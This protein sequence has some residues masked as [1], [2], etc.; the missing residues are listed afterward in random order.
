[1][2]GGATRHALRRFWPTRSAWWLVLGAGA[3]TLAYIVWI[4]VGGADKTHGYAISQ[5]LFLPVG[6]AAVALSIQ[7]AWSHRSQKRNRAAWALVAASL[8]AFWLGEV[9]WVIAETSAEGASSPSW[10]DLFYLIYYPLLL[11]ALMLLSARSGSRAE[12]FRTAL[13]AA[14][15]F[16][17]GAVLV[18][19]FVLRPSLE[20][21]GSTLE[22]VVTVAYPTGDLLLILGIASLAV[23]RHRFRSKPALIALLCAVVFGFAADLGYGYTSLLDAY[24]GTGVFEIVYLVSWFL[25]ALAAAFEYQAEQ[26]ISEPVAAES[27]TETSASGPHVLPFLAIGVALAV[28]LWALRHTFSTAEAGAAVAAV[29]VTVL[30]MV[31]QM[32]A[33]SHTSRLREQRSLLASEERFQHLLRRTQFSVDHVAE[34]MMWTDSEGQIVDV[35]TAASEMLDYS[36][37]ELLRMTI[38]QI[39]PEFEEDPVRWRQHWDTTKKQG[40]RIIE[41]DHRTKSGRM[42]PV[43]VSINYLEYSGEEFTVAF[44]HDISERRRAEETLRE[45][46]A[47]LRQAQKMDAIGQLAGGIAHDFNNLLTTIVGYCELIL[48]SGEGVSEP[49]RADVEEIKAAAE[50]ATALTRRILLFSRQ[51]PLQSK[52]V[53]LNEVVADVERLLSRTL[54]EHVELV[55]ILDPDAG[56]VEV[57]VSQFEQAITNLAVNARDAMPQGGRLTIETGHIDLDDEFCALRPGMRPGIHAVLVVSD[58]GEGMDEDT[59]VRA[60][61][62]FF[63][64]KEAGKGTGLGLTT[65]YGTAKQSGGG[66]FIYSEKGYGSAVKIYLPRVAEARGALGAGPDPLPA[67]ATRAAEAPQHS[68]TVLVVEDED[69]IRHLVKR[70]L[71]TRGYQ[72]LQAATA[73]EAVPILED[74][75]QEIDM[76]LTDVILPGSMQGGELAKRAVALRPNLP[77]LYMSGY[78]HDTVLQA[79]RLQDGMHYLEKPFT[80]QALSRRVREVLDQGL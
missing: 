24:N 15:I 75:A 26:R 54:G 68:E 19:Y 36:N 6:A 12:R 46:A 48:G 79:G 14:T 63:T 17:G 34:A 13:D 18:W 10:A 78:T 38:F 7:A 43:E 49:V 53:E 11:A 58:T 80:P 56:R 77:I 39:V 55:T 66:V 4:A 23:G 64:T 69:G 61:E 33:M 9:L 52:V 67:A 21:L 35:N 44:A 22:G 5:A 71:A 73:D 16:L 57:D 51:Q 72:V 50:R 29:L 27:P 45:T 41:T 76:L 47:Q 28:L 60:F 65:V 62:P 70:V 31:R 8:A 30:A 1:V 42:L 3:L 32:V 40:S 37:D 25:F 20:G 2:S 59:K 74:R